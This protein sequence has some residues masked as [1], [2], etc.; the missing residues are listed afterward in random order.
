M[1]SA[2]PLGKPCFRLPVK[3]LLVFFVVRFAVA[4]SVQRSAQ[5]LGGLTTTMR[6]SGGAIPRRGWRSTRGHRCVVQRASNAAGSEGP[7]Q[8]DSASR[9]NMLEGSYEGTKE[10]TD[11][12]GKVLRELGTRDY[13]VS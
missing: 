6:G 11:D 2:G 10:I 1:L 4:G 13:K 5:D 3:A 7:S 9:R 8:E 12:M